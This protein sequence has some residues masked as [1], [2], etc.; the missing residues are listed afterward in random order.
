VT[1][2]DGTA[3]GVRIT[4]GPLVSGGWRR[5][6]ESVSYD[7]GDNVG[8]KEMRAYLD[9]A[10]RASDPRPCWYGSKTPCPNGGGSLNVDT[11]GIPD[12]AHRLTVQ[13]ID[14]A[15]NATE[16]TQT[17]TTDNSAP[18][19]PSGMSVGGEAAWRSTNRFVVAWTNP[20]Q[21]GGPVT[22]AIYRL[23]PEANQATDLRGCTTGTRSATNISRIDDL[24]V[25]KPGAWT[26]RLW[27]RDAAGNEAASS[28]VS[29]PGLRFDATP[30]SI[31]FRAMDPDDPTRVRVAADDDVSGVAARSHELRRKGG[32][33]WRSLPVS[34]EAGG[35][36]GVVDD[37]VLRR[38]SYDLRARVV[39]AAGNE[40]STDT[41]PDGSP[42]RLSLPLRIR[43]RLVV[44]EVKKSRT[45]GRRRVIRT[46]HAHF[47]E[48]V[49]LHGRLTMPGSNPVADTDIEVWEKR[50]LPG[51]SWRRV[52]TARTSRTGR[53][54][55]RAG[56]GPNRVLRFRY[57]GTATIRSRIALV[58]IR[59]HARSSLRV[60][61]RRVLNG[62]YVTFRGRV[63]GRRFPQ[64]GKLVELQVFNRRRWRT[65]AQ[66][67]ANSTTGRWSYSYRFEAITGRVTFR[68]RAR[69][70]KE[71]DFP[72]ELGRSRQV[73][74]TV[75]GI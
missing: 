32:N 19:S 49:T 45:R 65:F 20:P 73:R 60:R 18:A 51:A 57:P 34:P 62:D 71:T 69:I 48:R 31:A 64:A 39:D 15:N 30:P 12:G 1:I 46:P 52:G 54:G 43:T 10:P 66:P 41:R 9:G 56:R 44:G 25:P 50:G 68:F 42:M 67:R 37:G 5:G 38:G 14:S 2:A 7:A 40:R 47:G 29:L 3:P 23:C 26:L 28:A 35:F 70:R 53:F 72:F 17:I 74:V 55:Y 22:A 61:P 16:A 36:S 13:A 59:V 63:R 24:S 75:R 58:D 21:S 27:L 4:G 11:S 8:I 6:A 33:S